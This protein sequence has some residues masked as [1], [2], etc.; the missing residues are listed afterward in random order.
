MASKRKE[1]LEGRLGFFSRK[2]PGTG[3]LFLILLLSSIVF[4]ILS[5]ALINYQ[6]LQRNMEAVLVSGTLSSLLL[7]IMPALITVLT[8]KLLKRVIRIKH[9]LTIGIVANAVYG[10]FFILG[11]AVYAITGS[12]AL[13]VV[14]V[15]LGDASI[16]AGWFM[17]SKI[18]LGRRKSASLY[19]L[20][21]PS[22]NLLLFAPSSSFL[23]SFSLPLN[24][25][26]IK[27][28]ASIFIF[29][30]ISYLV[31]FIFDN[32]IRRSIGLDGIAV[33]SQ[34]VQSWL[35]NIDAEFEKSSNRS[36][37]IK[38]DVDTDTIVLK[39]RDGRLKAV[40]FSPWI[41]YGPAGTIGGSN[42]PFVLEKHVWDRYGVPGI[43]MHPTINE[44]LN[45]VM[46]SQISDLK[47]ALDS[48]VKHARMVNGKGA[49]SYCEGSHNGATVK[50]LGMGRLCMTTFTRAPKVTEDIASEVGILF[51][52]MLEQDGRQHMLLDAHNS[53]YESASKQE[54]MGVQPNSSYMND[55]AEAIKRVKLGS[56]GKSLSAGIGFSNPYDELGAPQDLAPGN[57]N[58]ILFKCNGRRH[59]M[60]F[61]NANNMMPSLRDDIVRHMRSKFSIDAEVYTTDTHFVNSLNKT[62]SN[63]LGRFTQFKELSKFVDKAVSTAILNMEPV[64]VY[65]K[66]H[67]MKN[68]MVWGPNV[69][70]RMNAVVSSVFGL[71]RVAVP[72][73][74]A[75]G[76]VIAA[77]L[78]TIV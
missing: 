46:D 75:V 41:H 4:G 47:A 32:P 49:Y 11:A 43:I 78:I 69:R 28:Y 57:I 27:L 66:R 22:L 64:E 77:W 61:F 7:F 8:I 60:I 62:A 72:L 71:A 13:F 6:T 58:V 45:P 19:A 48:S 39:K 73:L 59:G 35:F 42:F 63:V 5:L 23:F 17:I 36:F 50:C 29:L 20:L 68:F 65:H 54:L 3:A 10:I 51:K 52:K 53:R 33:F 12:V 55:Y 76:F 16:F 38:Q 40:L 44:D 37:G 34:M 15:L 21:Q 9:V 70:E 56:R 74:I 30:I 1:G 2:L 25:L 24:V 31:L 67:V 18:A 26:L 14:I